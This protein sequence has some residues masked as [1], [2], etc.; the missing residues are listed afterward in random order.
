MKLHY[1]LIVTALSA[2]AVAAAADPA[3][4]ASPL[5]R[6]SACMDRTVDASSGDCVV[7][8]DGTPRRTYPPKR[9]APVA[10]A[11]SQPAPASSTMRKAAAGK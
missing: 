11:A 7:K 3:E 6:N 9:A 8:D 1:L 5:D 4:R 2:S 10:A